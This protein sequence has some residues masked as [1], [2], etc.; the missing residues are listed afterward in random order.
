MKPSRSRRKKHGR[1]MH[2]DACRGSRS[3][4]NIA[5]RQTYIYPFHRRVVPAL[6]SSLTS[7]VNW[8]GQI[9]YNAW[10]FVRALRLMTR[11]IIVLRRFAGG[12]AVV[13]VRADFPRQPTRSRNAV[14][15]FRTLL[16]CTHLY[17][18]QPTAIKLVRLASL[19][20]RDQTVFVAENVH[21]SH[22][23]A[24]DEDQVGQ[25][26]LAHQSGL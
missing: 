24:V 7:R 8:L 15:R 12:V 11:Q 25:K 9:A 3:G 6:C 16:R 17:A 13:Q 23:V 2:R 10:W 4:S 22:R 26:P 5:R 21:V 18:L 20:D 1:P 19:N 14:R